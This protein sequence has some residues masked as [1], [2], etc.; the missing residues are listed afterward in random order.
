MFWWWTPHECVLGGFR[1]GGLKRR[2]Q[3]P[4][5]Q[6]VDFA[7]WMICDLRQHGAEIE[8]RIEPAVG[9]DEEEVFPS[10]GDSPERP[11]RSA[12]VDLDQAILGVARKS[13]PAR[14]PHSESRRRFRFSKIAREAKT[15]PER[16]PLPGHLDRE[17]V[18]HPGWRRH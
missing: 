6:I 1:C 3:I 13:T 17:V 8:F 5:Q 10:E 7:D 9:S 12:V 2:R 4:W 11:L 16:K 18:M 15:R 14:E